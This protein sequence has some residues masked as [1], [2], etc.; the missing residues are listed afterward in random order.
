VIAAP[1]PPDEPERLRALEELQI[2]DTPPEETFDDIARLAALVCGTPI[3]AIDFAD[4]RRVWLKA[5]IGMTEL[6]EVPRELTFCTHALMQD[7]LFV[8][9]DARADPR[10]AGNP[11]VTGEPYVRFYAGAPL[12][13]SDGH[14][15]GMLCVLDYVPRDHD[16]TQR[17]TLRILARQVVAQLELRTGI[18]RMK[19][20][21]ITT[22][23]H[24]LRTPLTSIRGSL[25]LLAAGAGG[26]LT[27]DA[28]Q[29][30]AVA[31]R[32]SVRLAA[33]INDI[34]DYANVEL[35]PRP[36]RIA[37]LIEDAM[38][39]SGVRA[40]VYSEPLVVQADEKRLTQAI[41]NLLTFAS[42]RS[43]EV[44]VTVVDGEVRIEDRGPMLDEQAR[45]TLFECLHEAGT[46]LALALARAIIERHGGTLRV[47]SDE[48]RTTVRFRLP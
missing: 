30:L 42:R 14:A 24:E 7:S 40:L 10:F 19:N 11:F 48:Q 4:E 18:T 6:R 43:D 15:V 9:Q 12:V 27:T 35:E 41:V 3:A 46:G 25:G 37:S 32:N 8:I 39:Q 26:E 22:I 31:E 5:A 28:Q 44:H 1:V 33:L 2:L 29:M 45:A 36:V 17:D 34:L 38:L 13:L 20:A 21:F 16:A 47:E 23:N